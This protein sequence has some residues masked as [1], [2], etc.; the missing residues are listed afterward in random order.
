MS[1][2]WRFN[3]RDYRNGY[4][5]D[6]QSENRFQ[7]FKKKKKDAFNKKNKNRDDERDFDKAYRKEKNHHRGY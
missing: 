7:R 3:P 5:D 2:K 6:F 4:S 1:D